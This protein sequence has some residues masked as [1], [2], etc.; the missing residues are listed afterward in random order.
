MNNSLFPN[1]LFQPK[2][3]GGLVTDNI[4]YSLYQKEP[5]LLQNMLIHIYDQTTVRS[6]INFYHSFP[7]YEVAEE[8]AFYRWKIKGKEGKNLP[9][10][11]CETMNGDSVSG[12]TFPAQIGANREQF[13]LVFNENYFSNTEVIKGETDDYHF[14]I[15][16]TLEEA[17]KFKHRVE[18]VNDDLTLQVPAEYLAL[19]KRFTRSHGLTPSTLSYEGARPNFTSDFMMQNR[20][21]QCRIEYDVPGNMIEQG[22]NYPLKFGFEFQGQKTA[23]WINYV[24]LVVSWMAEDFMTKGAIYGK[25]NWKPDGTFLNFDDKNKFEIASGSG[26]FEQIAPGNRHWYNNFDLDNVID[27]ALDMSIGKIDRTKRKLRIVTGERGAIEIHKAIDAK[28]SNQWTLVLDGLGIVNKTKNGNLGSTNTFGA[29]MQYNEYRSYNGIE[30]Q[31]EIADFMDDDTYFPQLHPEGK[32]IAESHR[33]IIMGFGGEPGIYRTKVK[34]L[35]DIHAVVSGIRD[36]W[37]VGGKGHM[38]QAASKVDGYTP[39]CM[40]TGGMLLTD[41]TKIIDLRLNVAV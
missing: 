12:G 23:M 37:S 4:F 2:D 25:K 28:Q 30:L 32:G 41:P 6:M 16:E 15:K 39:I 22:R 27:M 26:L 34:G 20:L 33:M 3:Y 35:E 7:V 17:G 38:K 36:P 9:L 18:L 19:N 13:W 1:A 31:V 14:L 10:I 29:G 5:E 8:N 40:K 21:S 24:D 11:D